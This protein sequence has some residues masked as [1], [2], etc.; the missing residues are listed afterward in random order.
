ELLAGLDQVFHLTK[1]HDLQ[2]RKQIGKS[3]DLSKLGG[4]L[5]TAFSKTFAKINP[6]GVLVQGDAASTYYAAL[7]AFHY[8]LPIFY[9]EAG[10]RTYDINQ[11]F[12]EEGYRQMISRIATLCFVPTSTNRENLVNEGISK[13]KIHLVGNT[14]VDALKKVRSSLTKKEKQDLLKRDLPSLN[15]RGL[16]K[17][18]IV[19]LHRRENYG[20]PLKEVL[21]A[22]ITLA[23]MHPDYLFIFP[24]HP[25]RQIYP[26]V[27]NYLGKRDGFMV[28]KP[29]VYLTFMALLEEAH[30]VI[31]DSGGLQEEAPAFGIGVIVVREKT[32][33]VEGLASGWSVVAGSDRD[34]IFSAFL[35]F[36]KWKKPGGENPYGDGKAGERIANIIHEYFS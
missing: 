26:I 30:L 29:P 4:S 6:D 1:H 24:A 32:E 9:V 25:S 16:R 28:V 7:A 20:R 3:D 31:T 11:P 18:V 8:H 10:L 19:E 34:K 14:V 33:R 23:S 27:A 12:P 13:A 15:K 21:N 17:L 36:Q 5:L 35:H 22:L 2:I